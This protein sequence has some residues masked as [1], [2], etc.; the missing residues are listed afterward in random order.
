MTPKRGRGQRKLQ[1]RAELQPRE[2]RGGQPRPRP[3][4]SNLPDAA[5]RRVD[6][7]ATGPRLCSYPVDQHSSPRKSKRRQRLAP[8]SDTPAVSLCRRARGGVRAVRG[9]RRALLTWILARFGAR[10]RSRVPGHGAL[11]QEETAIPLCEPI[12]SP[13]RS[14]RGAQRRSSRRIRS[15]GRVNVG[16]AVP[17]EV[18]VLGLPPCSLDI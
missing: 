4:H 15:A 8:R 11:A 17:Q 12:G 18:L 3:S 16:S 9:V 2:P 7:P 13:R 14:R 10:P 1:R 6:E 5:T